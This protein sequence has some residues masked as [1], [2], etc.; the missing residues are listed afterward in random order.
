M[1]TADTHMHVLE[2]VQRAGADQMEA[3]LRGFGVGT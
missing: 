3:L 1:T 2:D